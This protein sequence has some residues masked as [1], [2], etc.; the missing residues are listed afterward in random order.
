MDHT[1][2]V[3]CALLLNALLA[4]P[5]EWYAALKLTRITTLPARAI[6]HI[7]RKLNRDHRLPEDLRLRGVVVVMAALIVAAL[8]GAMLGWIFQHNLRFIELLLVA[9]LL[10]VRPT[11]DRVAALRKALLMGNTPA[12]KQELSGTAWRHYALLDEYGVARAGIEFLAVEFSE[13]IVCPVLGYLLLGLPGLF[14]CKILTLLQD[15]L[16]HAPQFGRAAQKA[17]LWLN[18]IP[19]RISALLWMIAACFF[20]M[21]DPANIARRIGKPLVDDTPRALCV[22]MASAVSGV[23]LGGPGSPYLS[24]WTLGS[25]PRAL[26]VDIKRAQ[27]AYQLATL[28][29]FV[30]AGAFF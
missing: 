12:A 22:Q 18:I 7:E 11:W 20:P 2:I 19:S 10:P 13:K 24:A 23:A 4:G 6:R 29:L 16:I 27:N 26:P 25:S 30:L 17:Q 14:I 9:V 28:F 5:R 8:I 15:A 3:L 21:A 1:V